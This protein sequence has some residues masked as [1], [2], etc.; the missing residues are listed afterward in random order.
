[1]VQQPSNVQRAAR[2]YAQLD[3]GRSRQL[4]EQWGGQRKGGAVVEGDGELPDSERR[5]EAWRLESPFNRFQCLPYRQCQLL[6]PQ[7]RRHAGRRAGPRD[8]PSN[9]NEWHYYLRGTAQVGLFGSGGRGRVAEFKPGDV[10]YLPIGYGHAIRNIGKDDLEFHPH[11]DLIRG[12]RGRKYPRRHTARIS[13][14]VGM[15]R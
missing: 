9:A 2:A 5:V 11:P 8:A 4:A 7:R 6:R 1:M 10:A 14:P 12:R 15:G 3:A 13:C